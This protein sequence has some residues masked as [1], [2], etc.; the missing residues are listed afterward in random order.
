[1]ALEGRVFSLAANGLISL[2]DVPSD[3]PLHAELQEADCRGGSA[4]AGPDGSWVVEPVVG[5]ERLVMADLDLRRVAEERHNFH[6]TGHYS[7][8][9]VVSVQ[10]DRR[11]LEAAHFTD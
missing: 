1:M 7:R 8:A 4:I 9:D 5:E 2:S 6:P 10:V 3:F 11:R